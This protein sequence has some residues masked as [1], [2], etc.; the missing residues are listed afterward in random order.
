[1]V[2]DFHTHI[3]PRI[4]DGS[5]NSDMSVE[6]I[7]MLS[8]QG[9][10]AIIATPHF[11]Y[12]E[13]SIKDF[14]EDR[15]LSLNSLVDALERRNIKDRPKIILGAEVK[16]YHGLDTMEEA[17][18]LCIGGT[19]YMLV[20]M[21]FRNWETRDY[22]VL[23]RLSANRDIIP[24]IAHIERYFAYN[25]LRNMMPNLIQ[26][27]ALVQVNAE[28]L[29][30]RLTRLTSKYMMKNGLIQF[31]GTDCHDTRKRKPNYKAAIEVIEKINKGRYVDDLNFWTET[32]MKLNPECI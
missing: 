27:G 5:K 16:F 18:V 1:M 2:I 6:M 11:C 7:K 4:D 24:V 10:D 21:P 26:I 30:S 29:T 13:I 23:A 28:F 22:A 17:P 20:E 32:F 15:K 14:L 31:I 8:V 3:L 9:V 19:K 25:S 12:D